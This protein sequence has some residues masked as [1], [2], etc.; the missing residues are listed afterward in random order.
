MWSPKSFFE[1]EWNS[2]SSIFLKNGISNYKEGRN[3][4]AKPY[5]SK[6]SPYLHFGQIS[7][8]YLLLNFS[9]LHGVGLPGYR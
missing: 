2:P 1:N 5:V 8:E 4:P 3:L 9:I 6:L 7:K